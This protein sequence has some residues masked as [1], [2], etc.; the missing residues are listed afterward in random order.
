[1]VRPPELA[2]NQELCDTNT[3]AVVAACEGFRSPET[4]AFEFSVTVGPVS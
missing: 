1:M 2:L 4:L 3:G